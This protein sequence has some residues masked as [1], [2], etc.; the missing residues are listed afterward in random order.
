[1]HFMDLKSI[2]L[3]KQVTQLILGNYKL[4]KDIQYMVNVGANMATTLTVYLN[5]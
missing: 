2:R 4:F 5:Y 1:M 3:A